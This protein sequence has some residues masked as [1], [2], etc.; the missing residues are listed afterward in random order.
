MK[1]DALEMLR[2][3]HAE[4][5]HIRRDIHA[6]PE[7]GFEE[8]R[9]SQLV[10]DKLAE[11]GIAVHRG[12]AK[13]GVV[14][15]VKGKKDS[16]RAIGLRADMDCLPM[17]ETGDAP[18]KSRVAGRMHACGHDGH[19]TMLLGAARYLAQTRNFDGT[20]HLIF[21]P[22]E[23]GGGG[24]RV[25][26]EEGLFARFP[27]DAV[28]AIH[29]WPG[30]PPG[31]IAVRPGPMMAATDEIKMKIR[32]R[33]GHAALPHLAV[34]PVVIAAHVITALQTVASRNANPVDA[35]VVSLCSMQTSQL[36]AFN[37]IPAQVELIGTVRTFTPE[38]RDLAE[39]RIR[40]I[41]DAVA[42]GLG[43]SA[44]IEYRR[45]Y[46]ATVNSEAEAR[47]AARVGEKVFGKANVV[48]DHEPTM[49]GED[50]SYMLQEKP[51][52]YVFLG[53][54]GAQGGCFLH[55]PTYDFNDEVIPLG[56]GYLAALV[57]DS[58]PLK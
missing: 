6:N 40:E 1:N 33:G 57:E 26:V 2:L 53:Q 38:M 24:G 21:Q 18:H 42:L 27:C 39:R 4:L 58:L 14:G 37:V 29:N 13:T 17:N 5:V 32:G 55:N 34:D 20:V 31:K 46:P 8:T 41:A 3:F 48:T 45:G 50:F 16:G 23:E 7:L 47:F 51:G 10:A 43:G 28:Y 35:L 52:A 15:V 19:T 56:A 12:L 36:G 11:W 30:L 54:G 25:M 22:A 44:E 9:T 49:G